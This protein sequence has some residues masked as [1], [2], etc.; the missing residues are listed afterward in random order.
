MTQRG[1]MRR[2]T[3]SDDLGSTTSV[4]TRCSFW[5]SE[6]LAL[7]G[8]LEDACSVFERVVRHANPHGLFSEDIDPET[9][10]LLG[11][12]PLIDTHVSLINAAMT[13]GGLL[14]ARDGRIR[15]WR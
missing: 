10:Q 9:G 3:N 12:F 11:N 13:I 2:Y 4:F 6:A 1:L 14:D 15:A 7:T 8:R 5:W